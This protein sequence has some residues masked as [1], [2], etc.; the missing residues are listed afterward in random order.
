MPA[1]AVSKSVREM[2]LLFLMVSTQSSTQNYVSDA[3]NVRKNARQVLSHWRRRKN[4]A[5]KEVV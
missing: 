4:E 1:D 3:E 5:K 2:Q